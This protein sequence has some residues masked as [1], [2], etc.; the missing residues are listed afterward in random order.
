MTLREIMTNRIKSYGWLDW[1]WKQNRTGKLK[2]D[3][4]RYTEYLNSLSDEDFV[5]KF[6][7]ITEAEK[8]LD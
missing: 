2:E 3:E 5:D 4:T 6:I 7:Y 8:G 1:E